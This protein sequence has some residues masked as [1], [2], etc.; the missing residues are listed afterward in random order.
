MTNSKRPFAFISTPTSMEVH[1]RYIPRTY[2]SRYLMSFTG[3]I[4]KD[5]II[6]TPG[7]W[8]NFT[9][10]SQHKS[11]DAHGWRCGPDSPRI[12][13]TRRLTLVPKTT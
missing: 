13:S 1:G 7:K 8:D 12:Y 4:V 11:G 5:D 2:K 9:I 10:N 3:H 6:P